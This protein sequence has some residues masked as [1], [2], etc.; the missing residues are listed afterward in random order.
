MRDHKVWWEG[1]G[2]EERMWGEQVRGK[3]MFKISE[4]SLKYEQIH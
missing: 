3:K 2:G 4:K 1:R